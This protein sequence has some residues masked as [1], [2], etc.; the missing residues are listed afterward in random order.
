LPPRWNK[1]KHWLCWGV[2]TNCL[3]CRAVHGGHSRTIVLSR[4]S[5]D[6]DLKWYWTYRWTEV[7]QT[8]LQNQG[9]KPVF[10]FNQTCCPYLMQLVLLEKQ[11]LLLFVGSYISTFCIWRQSDIYWL[12]PEVFNKEER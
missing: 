8:H 1:D 2:L 12:S 6:V 7:V 9:N 10:D 5:R 4:E 11:V 3:E